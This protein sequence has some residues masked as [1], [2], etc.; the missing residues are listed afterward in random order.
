[1][2]IATL[3]AMASGPQV[4]MILGS[5]SHPDVPLSKGLAPVMDGATTKP[6]AR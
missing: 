2:M 3:T 4:S 1:M 5:P 6:S